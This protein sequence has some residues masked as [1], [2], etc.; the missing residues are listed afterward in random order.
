MTKDEFMRAFKAL[1]QEEKHE[2]AEEIMRDYCRFPGGCV[3]EMMSLCSN[4]MGGIS[5]FPFGTAER[6]GERV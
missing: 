2:V 5:G 6:K 1:S 3:G 4:M